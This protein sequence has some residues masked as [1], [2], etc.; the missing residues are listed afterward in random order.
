[1]GFFAFVKEPFIKSGSRKNQSIRSMREIKR[2]RL[3]LGVIEVR[4]NNLR[5]RRRGGSGVREVKRKYYLW[6]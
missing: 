5:K 6:N 3:R 1:M 4:K 2:L